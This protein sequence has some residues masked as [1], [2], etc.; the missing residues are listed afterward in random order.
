MTRAEVTANKFRFVKRAFSSVPAKE[1]R[2]PK[3]SPMMRVGRVKIVSNC[4]EKYGIWSSR[5]G[6]GE[7]GEPVPC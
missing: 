4:F 1:N 5:G 6:K 2:K 7:T 3:E